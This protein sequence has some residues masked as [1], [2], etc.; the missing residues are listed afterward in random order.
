MLHINQFVAT[1]CPKIIK[2]E[3]KRNNGKH[4]IKHKIKN[5][6]KLKITTKIK[7]IKFNQI[8]NVESKK[9]FK[10]AKLFTKEK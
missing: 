7:K 9:S 6:I 10:K 3:L 8:K 2:F 1:A 5:K 4:K